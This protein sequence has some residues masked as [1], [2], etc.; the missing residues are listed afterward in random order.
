MPLPWA[1]GHVY[2]WKIRRSDVPLGN[3][4]ARGQRLVPPAST[5]S[6]APFTVRLP[7]SSQGRGKPCRRHPRCAPARPSTHAAAG[8]RQG[9]DC[10]SESCTPT[11]KGRALGVKRI[12]SRQTHNLPEQFCSSDDDPK[13]HCHPVN[14]F[15]AVFYRISLQS[16][17]YRRTWRGEK[18][19][20]Q[21]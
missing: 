18:W 17:K 13:K 1:C 6:A 7:G 8:D 12:A 9:P 14:C 20:S 5:S 3:T 10:G 11:L 16:Q 19:V 2:D 15:T 21:W 4:S